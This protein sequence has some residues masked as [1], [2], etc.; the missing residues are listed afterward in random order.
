[1]EF[2]LKLVLPP[3]MLWGALEGETTNSKS[4]VAWPQEVTGKGH[5]PLSS[6]ACHVTYTPPSQTCLSLDCKVCSKVLYTLLSTG[7]SFNEL[8]Y[9]N[10]SCFNFDPIVWWRSLR[11][12]RRLRHLESTGCCVCWSTVNLLINGIAED[13]A[14]IYG[15]L[16]RTDLVQ[17][18]TLSLFTIG[19]S[20][21]WWFEQLIRNWM[22][23]FGFS[24]RGVAIVVNQHRCD[25]VRHFYS[26]V[27]WSPVNCI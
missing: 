6:P 4:A 9:F 10:M 7:I 23:C 13:K 19:R 1:M 21:H 20:C 12:W 16:S 8:L 18:S 27:Y 5:D 14:D 17:A 26:T 25:A 2:F 24:L 22:I 15:L 3:H 11:F